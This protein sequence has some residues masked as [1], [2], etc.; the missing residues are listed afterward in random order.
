VACLAS[1]LLLESAAVH[2]QA[3]Y[4]S[5]PTGGRS[6][7][8]GGTGIALA[9]DGAAPF[10]NP[11]TIVR[12]DDSGVAF[13]VNFYT[14]QTTRLTGFHQPGPVDASR[15]GALSLPDTSL[16]NSRLDALPSTLCLFLTIGNWGDN[17]P[18]EAEAHPHRKGHRKL[19]ACLGSLERQAFGATAESYS[20]DSAGLHASQ[21]QSIERSWNR[22]YVGPSY[23]VYASDDV[24]IGV[25]L[26]GIGTTMTSNWNVDTV[27]HDA[28][29]S[30]SASSYGTSASAY[31]I[32]LGAVLGVMWHID[33]YQTLGLSLS[34]PTVHMLGQYHGTASIQTLGAGS[35]AILATSSGNFEAPPPMRIGVGLGMEKGRMRV[36]G[37]VS[38]YVPVTALSQADLGIDQ[39]TVGPGKTTVQSGVTTLGVTGRPIVDAAFGLEWFTS[40][41]FSLLGGVSTD[42]SAMD[43]LPTKPSIGTLAETRMQRVATSLGIGSYGDGSELLLGTE[44][45]YAWGK[46][47]AWDPF[48]QQ[49]QL[50][51]VDQRTFTAMLVVAGGMSLS[52]FR[53]TLKDLGGVVRLP[54]K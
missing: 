45:S 35:S 12:I 34:T 49:P 13:S 44:L 8:M 11:A 48:A 6:A 16:D 24:A 53:R 4:R 15:Y 23:S 36:E 29:T 39:T 43:P 37:D 5:A 17:A 1:A 18:I 41:G 22:I 2:A 33:H 9:R 10:L 51:L 28:A 3:N 21:A 47:I 54:G 30:A 26:H 14:I 40:P 25:S 19:A 38:A 27:V 46:S 52:A 32:D 7:L 50:A 42:L 20:G 31:S